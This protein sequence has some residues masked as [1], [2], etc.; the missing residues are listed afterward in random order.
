MLDVKID[1]LKMKLS[2]PFIISRLVMVQKL[3]NKKM[4]S[5]L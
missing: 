1:K 2:A 5:A 4:G 3:F